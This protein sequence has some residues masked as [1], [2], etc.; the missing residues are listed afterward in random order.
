MLPN[1]EIREVNLKDYLLILKKRIPVI[2][3]FLLIIPTVVAIRVSL[4]VPV[5]RATSNILIERRPPSASKEKYIYTT[6]LD[7]DTQLKV[8]K[9]RVLGERIYEEAKLAKDTDFNQSDDPVGALLTKVSFVN[10]R[11]T[12]VVLISADD[13]DALRAALIANAYARGYIQYDIDMRNRSARDSS[14]WLR[15]QLDEVKEKLKN[16][17]IN[18]NAYIQENKIIVTPDYRNRLQGQLEGLKSEK[19]QLE[20]QWAESSKRYKEK[21]PQMIA[22]KAQLNEV[23]TRLEQEITQ[24]LDLNNKMVQYNV[25]KNEVDSNQNLYESL[26]ESTKE[27]GVAEKGQISAIQPIDTAQVPG[28]P[29]K[30]QKKKA[31]VQ[32][33]LFALFGG[34]GFAIFLEYFDSSVPTAEDISNYI[35]L[36]FLGYVPTCAK[37][38]RGEGEKAMLCFRKPTSSMAECF[39]ALRT[40]IMFSSPEDKPLKSIII[41]SS[42]PGEGKSFLSLNLA[43]I[44]SQMN[45]KVIFIDGD[46]RRPKL[47]KNMN[48]DNKE[49]LS[50]YLIG[51]IN[52]DSI[53]KSTPVANLSIITSGP[54]PPNPSELLSSSKINSLLQE[55]GTKYDRI[56]VDAPPGLAVADTLLLANIVDGVLIV[57]KGGSTRLEPIIG[58][59]KKMLETKAK[60]IGVAINNIHPEKEDKYYYYHY[61]YS[62][63]K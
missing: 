45:E 24:M 18:L 5:F 44:F 35:N 32:A 37:E 33:L 8:L 61:Y 57:I 52:L 62:E 63:K 4:E 30:P 10:P 9:S 40:S 54:I 1:P 2:I 47:H 60:I 13:T 23:S 39:R 20:A 21:H 28:L 56:I 17:E 26:L 27:T 46:M 43:I 50:T 53:I 29:Y 7:I 15:E 51:G 31:I 34:I 19:S 22:L 14:V 11:K 48:I 36:P 6:P 16:A 55:L 25:L 59:K 38:D 12:N 3:G 41:T 42:L 58:T 49:G